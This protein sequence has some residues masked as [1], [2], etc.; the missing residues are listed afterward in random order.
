MSRLLDPKGK[1]G[2]YPFDYKSSAATDV[3]ET[4]ERIKREQAR[5]KAVRTFPVLS[6][7]RS[8]PR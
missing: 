1:D 6:K 2:K 8:A 7:L 3:R 4:F 5:D